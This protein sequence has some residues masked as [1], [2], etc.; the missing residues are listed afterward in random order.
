MGAT[1]VRQFHRGACVVNEQLLAGAVDLAHGA[2]EGLGVTA[3]VLAELRI[4]V[5]GLT[6]M[7]GA[8]FLPQQHQRHAL[9]TQLL[10]DAAVVGL[11]ETADSLGGAQ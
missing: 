9:A 3:V 4:S 5:G 11:H 2:L 6:R 7:L 1:A 8:M 10:V